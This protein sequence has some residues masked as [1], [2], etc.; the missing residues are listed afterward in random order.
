MREYNT[1]EERKKKEE[2]REIKSIF[3]QIAFYLPKE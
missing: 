2:K 1:E 3:K